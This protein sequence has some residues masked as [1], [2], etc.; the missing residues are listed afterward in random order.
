MAEVQT[1]D[2]ALSFLDVDRRHALKVARLL[3]GRAKMWVFSDHQDSLLGRD[4]VLPM[5]EVFGRAATLVVV[6]YRDGWGSTGWT[7][8]EREAINSRRINERSSEFLTV[9]RMDDSLLPTWLPASRIWGDWTP[10]GA[11]GVAGAIVSRLQE[12]GVHVRDESPADIARRLEAEQDWWKRRRTFLWQGEGQAA[13]EREARKVFTVI[14]SLAQQCACDFCAEPYVALLARNHYS[15]SV[16]VT[17]ST[18][19][20]SP[21]ELVVT[22]WNGRPNMGAVFYAGVATELSR[23]HYLFDI[24][25]PHTLVWRNSRD[26]AAAL[27][28]DKLAAE[29]V[30]GLLRRV[31]G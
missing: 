5:S 12:L 8:I 29:V 11:K 7:N 30:K 14:E 16:A 15:V 24:H 31:S 21:L 28:S 26:A 23:D 13:A 3:D 10:L 27:T 4:G 19:A 1:L 9:V 17:S 6:L 18:D 25:E 20:D 2:A 22:N